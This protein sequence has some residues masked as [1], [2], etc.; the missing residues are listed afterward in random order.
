[1]E[2]K[3]SLRLING[4]KLTLKEFQSCCRIEQKLKE[5]NFKDIYKNQKEIVNLV[6]QLLMKEFGSNKSVKLEKNPNFNQEQL[7]GIDCYAFRFSGG[8]PLLFLFISEDDK[9]SFIDESRFEAFGEKGLFI[10]PKI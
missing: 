3:A 1:M 10:K 8:R 4:I 9:F 6:K 7:K 5:S 2:E